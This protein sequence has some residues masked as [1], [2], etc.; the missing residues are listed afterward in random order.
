MP[1]ITL[2][3][4][5]TKFISLITKL[6]KPSRCVDG[7]CFDDGEIG[8]QELGGSIHMI[9]LYVLFHFQLFTEGS[10]TRIAKW[11]IR[12]GFP[13][14]GHRDGHA[15]PDEGESGC[16]FADKLVKI[17]LTSQ[18]RSEEI[19]NRILEV[20]G[21]KH[22]K[23]LRKVMK[24]LSAYNHEN[25]QISGESLI[26]LLESLG[27]QILKLKGIHEEGIAFVNLVEDTTFDT[28]EAVEKAQSAFNLDLWAILAKAKVMR[29]PRY[30]A[31]YASLILYVATEMVLV[32]DK[33]KPALDVLVNKK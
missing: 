8:P 24:M 27:G 19:V 20:I 14:G 16:G 11:L 32:E 13:I 6:S 18:N 22:E 5:V 7:R 1:T 2:V 28:N 21:K 9:L 23:N 12:L 4:M 26:S 30:F 3:E 29:I 10:V 15:D 25:I 17:F 33:G 31:F